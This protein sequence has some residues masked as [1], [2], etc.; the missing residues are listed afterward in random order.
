M[1][2]VDLAK[3]PS[4]VRYELRLINLAEKSAPGQYLLRCVR[5]GLNQSDLRR[6]GC[7]PFWL[8]LG[9][10]GYLPVV[11]SRVSGERSMEIEQCLA[12]LKTLSP[13]LPSHIDINI[14]E[15]KIP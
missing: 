3:K 9:A 6:F 10:D 12:S 8:G 4:H 2:D 1:P 15:E 7:S 13:H 14:V 11:S 5:S